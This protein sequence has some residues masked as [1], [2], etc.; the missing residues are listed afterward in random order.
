MRAGFAVR[1]L[2]LNVGELLE[3]SDGKGLA[4]RSLRVGITQSDDQRD[5]VLGGRR[6]LRA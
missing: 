1:P 4:V 6:G 5:I 3:V 2:R